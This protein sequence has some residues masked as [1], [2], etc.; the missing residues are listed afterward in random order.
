VRPLKWPLGVKWLIDCAS[1]LQ[2][3]VFKG[4]ISNN[5]SKKQTVKEILVDGCY[6]WTEHFSKIIKQESQFIFFKVLLTV[7]LALMSVK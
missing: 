4:R 3:L 1:E 2:N 5:K 7:H 6:K